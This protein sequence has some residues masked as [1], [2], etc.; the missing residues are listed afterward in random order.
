MNHTQVKAVM[1]SLW[2]YEKGCLPTRVVMWRQHPELPTSSFATHYET[3]QDITMGINEG[4]PNFQFILGHYDMTLED[5]KLDFD[6]RCLSLG[7][8][9]SHFNADSLI[10]AKTRTVEPCMSQDEHPYL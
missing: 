10:L 2:K 1:F 4:Y 8:K 3:K 6:R 5:A 7:V 9:F